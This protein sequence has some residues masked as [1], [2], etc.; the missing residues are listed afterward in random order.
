MSTPVRDPILADLLKLAEDS[1]VLYVEDE[2]SVRAE[3]AEILKSIFPTVVTAVNGLD[4]LQK[5]AHDSFS[6]VITDISMP[7]LDGIGLI[8]EIQKQ[9]PQQSFLVTSAYSEARH[10][11]PLINLGVGNFV[12]KPIDWHMF[13]AMLRKELA[14]VR[15]QDMEQRH[16]RRLEK[17][18]ALRTQELQGAYF[19]ISRLEEA[20]SNMVALVSHE[21]RTPLSGILGFVEMLRPYVDKAEAKEFLQFVDDS[22]HRLERSTKKALEYAGISTS[23]RPLEYHEISLKSLVEK[24]ALRLKEQAP[25]GPVADVH[26]QGSLSELRCDED[27]LQ[28]ALFNL[29]ENAQKY[30][31]PVP[32]IE[33][34]LDRTGDWLVL[35]VQDSGPGFSDFALANLFQPFLSGGIMNHSEG[36]GLG[37]SLVDLI[38][39]TMGGKVQADNLPQGGARVRLFL[40]AKKCTIGS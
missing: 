5:F 21:L 26:I 18:V 38:I 10:L 23:S 30:A 24:V 20:R 37:L 27:L 7:G 19:Q 14:Y 22:A 29:F 4:A 31:G 3:V 40:P 8:Q 12:L 17:E 35:T 2:D 6:V 1:S 28:E 9:K 11:I 39:L 33:I 25:D 16:Q 32:H 34:S 13:M 36:M 15:N